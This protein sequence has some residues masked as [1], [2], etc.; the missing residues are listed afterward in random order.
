MKTQA[1]K[2]MMP[3]ITASC[4]R[5]YRILRNTYIYFILSYPA[6]SKYWNYVAYELK[7][8]QLILYLY[9]KNSHQHQ[10][11][12]N[13]YTC[14]SN[15]VCLICCPPEPPE[16][17]PRLD[18]AACW[19][20]PPRETLNLSHYFIPT[21]IYRVSHKSVYTSFLAFFSDKTHPKCKSWECF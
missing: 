2:I 15:W 21:K 20:P 8:R 5:K 12:K 14:T 17:P 10:A 6:Q 4:F 1:M 11:T 7:S 18:V 13:P 3:K 9:T 19:P 16:S